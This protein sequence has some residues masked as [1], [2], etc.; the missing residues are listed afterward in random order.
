MNKKIVIAIDGPAGA[1]KTTVAKELAKKMDIPY[2]STGSMYRALALKCIQLGLDATNEKDANLIANNT[3]VG[4]KYENGKQYVLLDGENVTELLYTDQISAGA[5]QI[6]VHKIIR[7]K[8]VEI[9]RHVAQ[10]QSVIMDGRDIGSVVLPMAD[11][12]FYLD[13]DVKVRAKRRF[14]ELKSKGN[15][16]SFEE[17]LKD[18]KER[19]IRDKS[20][21]ISPLVICDDAIVIDSTNLSIDGVLNEF[22]KHIGEKK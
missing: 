7:E 9:Q 20:R 11:F 21:E 17:V 22:F 8:M 19:D 12:K 4:I 2:F 10:N 15:N 6:S 5:S 18:M 3:T 14:D 13:A 1:G 16:I